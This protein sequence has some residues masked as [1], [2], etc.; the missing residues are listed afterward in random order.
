M[1]RKRGQRGNGGLTKRPNGKWQA[2]WSFTEGGKR[3][4]RSETFTL[5]SDAEWWLREAKRG[6]E[7]DID[8]TVGEYLDG[9]L[10]TVR[11][12]IE[13]STWISYAGH[14]ER[15]LKPH[16]GH[17]PLMELQPRHVDRA[18]QRLLASDSTRGRPYS[19][20]TVRLAMTT[21]RIALG[22]AVKRRELPDNAASDAELPR[23][24]EHRIEPLTDEE[25]RRLVDAARDSWIGPLVRF[26][27][28]SGLR[29]GEAVGLDQRDLRLDEGYVQLR[30]SKRS[31]HAV[32]VS[33]DGIAALR[34]ALAAAPR[35]GPK[36]PVFFGPKTGDR[37][38]GSSVSHALPRILERAGVTRLSPHG[39]R[40]AHATIQRAHGTPMDDIADQ[41][42]HRNPAFTAKRYAH[43]TP[44]RLRAGVKALDEAL[45]RG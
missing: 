5:K 26:L 38:Q 35:R 18:T 25:A 6:N 28:G 32:S 12:R 2:Q 42:G 24:T 33:D 39:L 4:R 10:K 36:E 22:A 14:V 20:T 21:L 9:W 13:D 41:L 23:A 37:L 1:P 3:V 15:M 17:L 11:P 45:K 31:I 40:H 29:L 27:L 30:V 44:H 43:V 34:E 8:Q 16:L 7:P 19:P